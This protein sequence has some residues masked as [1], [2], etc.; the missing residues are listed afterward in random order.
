MDG[1]EDGPILFGAGKGVPNNQYSFKCLKRV[2]TLIQK[3]GHLERLSRFCRSSLLLRLLISHEESVTQTAEKDSRVGR[4]C[5]TQIYSGYRITC[6]RKNSLISLPLILN[7]R[8]KDVWVRRCLIMNF[9]YI[10]TYYFQF[11]ILCYRQ[12]SPDLRSDIGIFSG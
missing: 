2:F 11:R 12:S 6:P 5:P 10:R 7:H 4:P 3:V 8:I 1:G 9:M